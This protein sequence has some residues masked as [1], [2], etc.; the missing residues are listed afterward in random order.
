M[1]YKFLIS[2]L[3]VTV[4]SSVFA[5]LKKQQLDGYCGSTK[6]IKELIDS[7]EEKPIFVAPSQRFKNV[8]GILVV[9]LNSKTGNWTVFELND[10][11]LHCVLQTG[12][13]GELNFENILKSDKTV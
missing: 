7:Y 8:K 1:F 3:L 5:E 4:T 13:G 12:D 11:G 2:L 9:T 10:N 6:E